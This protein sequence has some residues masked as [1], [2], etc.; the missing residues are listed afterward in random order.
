MPAHRALVRLCPLALLGLA[1]SSQPPVDGVAMFRGDARHSGDFG[2]NG[3]ERFGGVRWRVQTDGPVRSSPTVLDTRVYVGSADGQLYALDRGS[4]TVRWRADVASPVTSSPAVA[5]GLVVVGSRDGTFHAR[6]AAS[7]AERWTFETGDL[8]SWDWGFEGWDAYTS[9][10]VV[11]DSL[12]VFGGGDGVLYAVAL[13]S[14]V[15]RWRFATEGRIRSSPAIADGLAVVGSAD[16]RVYAVDVVSGQERWRY[17]PEGVSLVSAEFGYDRKSIISSP[18]V[19]DGTVYVGSRDGYMYA[20]DQRTGAFKW[21][22][23]HQGSWAMSSAA[24]VDGVVYSGTSDGAFVHALDAGSGAELWRFVAEGYTWSSPA[25]TGQGV[26]IGDAAGTVWALDWAT[27]TVQS[28]YRVGGA[29]YSSPAVANG[30]VYVG[31]DDGGVYALYGDGE[32][33]HRAVFWDEAMRRLTGQASH[34]V[35]RA[36]FAEHGYDV[37]DADALGTFLEARIADGARSV[38]VFAMDH[39]PRSVAPEPSDTTLFRR[40]LDA[41]GKVVWLGLPP[42]VIARDPETQR[43]VGLNRAAGASLLGVGYDGLNFDAYGAQS[44]ELGKAWGAPRWWVSS[45][46]IDAPDDLDVLG[47]DE[48]GHAAAWVRSFGGPEGTGFVILSA[49]RVPFEALPGIRAMAEYGLRDVS[50]GP[51]GEG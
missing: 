3:L 6:D 15:E 39:L 51:E 37:V 2:D 16:G 41:G 14:G 45:Y 43:F 31:S 33:V 32:P 24:V 4:G 19:V 49:P 5:E 28:S 35:I 27:G 46:A 26:Y 38:V 1:C 10:P 9:S 30:V 21:R 40:Y 36:Y 22:A 50:G 12:V 8:L 25:V 42:L 23:D 20:L 44:T 29:V 13:A 47:L 48:N 34:E 18:A 11:T 7:G 17:E